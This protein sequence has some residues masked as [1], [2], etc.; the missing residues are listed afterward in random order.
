MQ[1]LA[2]I[3]SFIFQLPVQL[4]FLEVH[5]IEEERKESTR[6]GEG[7]SQDDTH[8]DEDI[9]NHGENLPTPPKS[10]SEEPNLGIIEGPHGSSSCPI[11]RELL[12]RIAKKV[13]TNPVILGIVGGF[14]LSLSTIGP[15]FLN[16][17]KPEDY[18]PG[19]GWFWS[20]TEWFGDCVSPVSLFTMGLWMHSQGVQLFQLRLRG[21]FF[22][23]L[24]KLVMVPFLMLLLA[25]AA[26]LSDEAGRAAVLIAA[27]P[28]SMAS[29]TLASN[30]NI[31][32]AILSENVA[33]GTILLLPTI[34]IWNLVLD[35]LDVFPIA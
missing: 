3:S 17:L 23:M 9:E 31:G 34:L 35:A 4:L 18:I 14:F 5:A 20:T 10:Q 22:F 11:Q 27:L 30:Y 15:R 19:L 6:S 7:V 33:M 1:Q 21:V 12:M 24:S 26:D 16:P 8:I 29:F 25:L 2:G 13:V 28:I 32:Q